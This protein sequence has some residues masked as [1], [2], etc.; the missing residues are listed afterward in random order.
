[1]NAILDAPNV[2]ILDRPT[3]ELTHLGRTRT[4]LFTLI[5][6]L[7]DAVKPGDDAAVVAAVAGLSRT[8]RLRRSVS[9]GGNN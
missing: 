3:V 7:Q 1:M 6:A 2:D 9:G 8:G 5:S 4:T